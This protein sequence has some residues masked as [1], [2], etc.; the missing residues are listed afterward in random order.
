MDLFS[1][2]FLI[3]STGLFLAFLLILVDHPKKKAIGLGIYSLVVLLILAENSLVSIFYVIV[4][5][6]LIIF[7]DYKRI[8]W[9]KGLLYVSV[10]GLFMI[11][12]FKFLIHFIPF[13][14]YPVLVFGYVMV[15]KKNQ[16]NP[17]T[18]HKNDIQ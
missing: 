16:S 18:V 12:T 10:S 13:Y 14:I 1:K 5:S 4:G 9:K 6:P 17:S 8:N 7:L 3:A 15:A 11:L 2:L